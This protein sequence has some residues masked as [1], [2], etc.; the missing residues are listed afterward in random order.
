MTNPVAAKRLLLAASESLRA[1]GSADVFASSPN[2]T[3]ARCDALFGLLRDAEHSRLKR[4]H[5]LPPTLAFGDAKEVVDN[6]SILFRVIQ[7]MPK[8]A[9]LHTHIGALASRRWM[10]E[11]MKDERDLWVAPVVSLGNKP[12]PIFRFATVQPSPTPFDINAIPHSLLE[13][14]GIGFVKNWP[15]GGWKRVVDVACADFDDWVLHAFECIDR[16]SDNEWTVWAHFMNCFTSAAGVLEYAPFFERYVMYTLNQYY[17][18][19]IYHLEARSTNFHLY[20]LETDAL[21][22]SEL[23]TILRSCLAAFNADKPLLPMSLKIIYCSLRDINRTQMRERMDECA[24]LY[25]AFPDILVGFDLVGHEENSPPLA[26][27][28]EAYLARHADPCAGPPLP[29]LVLHAGETAGE[30]TAC[31]LN[32]FDAV[33]LGARRVGHGCSVSRYVGAL[34]EAMQ[35]VCVEMCPMSNQILRLYPNLMNHPL[36][37]LLNHGIPVSISSDDPGVFGYEGVDYDYYMMAVAFHSI[38]LQT[39]KMVVWNSVR[40]ALGC[41]DT[42]KEVL[43]KVYES[44]WGQFM[45]WLEGVGQGLLDEQERKERKEC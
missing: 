27:F 35:E 40:F 45:E 19:G 36:P 3:E 12:T 16:A 13:E 5:K 22:I 25:A 14:N 32:V 39:L 31:A 17:T 2:E 23:Y 37:T 9:L 24:N 30:G 29:P 41:D 8:M 43:K 15:P 21:P 7:R 1:K 38:G 44:E 11:A 42:R 33:A 26:L 4:S 34:R 6:D 20:N 28:A 18:L 10:V